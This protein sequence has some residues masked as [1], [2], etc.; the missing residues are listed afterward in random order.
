MP[1]RS[2]TTQ[3]GSCVFLF[4]GVFFKSFVLF[5]HLGDMFLIWR[6]C[7]IGILFVLIFVF[8]FGEGLR[9]TETERNAK[10]KIMSLGG[11]EVGR[12]WEEGGG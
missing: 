12:T 6:F 9:E 2:R 8:C 3:Y 10:S 5:W 11:R 4:C 7:L 1:R